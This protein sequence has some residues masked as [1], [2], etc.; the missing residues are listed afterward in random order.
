LSRSPLTGINHDQASAETIRS[1]NVFAV[2]DWRTSV[3]DLHPA[4][5]I[6]RFPARTLKE[7]A[8]LVRQYAIECGDYEGW[9]LMRELRRA[10]GILESEEAERH[11]H[12]WMHRRSNSIKSWP[13][14]EEQLL[15]LPSPQTSN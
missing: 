8:Y 7:A 1:P 13:F 6:G 9:L 3:L 11:L 10:E 5:A 14:E 12:Q 15:P 2:K 4:I